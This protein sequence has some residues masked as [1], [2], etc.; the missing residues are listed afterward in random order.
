MAML[1]HPQP[2]Y[3]CSESPPELNTML[4]KTRT[5]LQQEFFMLRDFSPVHAFSPPSRNDWT[6]TASPMNCTS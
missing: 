3:E 4:P 1:S 6:Y 5:A 2:G